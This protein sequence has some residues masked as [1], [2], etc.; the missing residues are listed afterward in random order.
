M[1]E[2]YHVTGMTCAACSSRVEKSV[3]VLPGIKKVSVNLLKNS[4]IVDYDTAV[5]N[6]DRIIEAVVKAG[7]GASLQNA[8]RKNTGQAESSANDAKKRIRNYETSGHLVFCFYHPVILYFYGSYDGMAVAELFP[9][10]R[11]FHD[12]CID[13]VFVV[14]P[15]RDH[16]FKI[17]PYWF[18]NPVSRFAQ[19]GFFDRIGIRSFPGLRHLCS[20]QD[21]IRVRPRRFGHGA[22][23]YP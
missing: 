17:L 20:L 7:Y 13:P 18:Q 2:R 21:C 19:H 11:E 12:L 16:Q 8:R 5:L 22:S 23:I 3:S 6:S 15:G 10:H 9:W 14:A 1:Q 4:M